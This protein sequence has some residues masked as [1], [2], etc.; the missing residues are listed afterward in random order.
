LIEGRIWKEV[1]AQE[2]KYLHK[3]EKWDLVDLPN[4][5]KPISIKWVLKKNLNRTGQVKKYKARMVAKWYSQVEGVDFIDIFSPIVKL[6]SIRVLMSLDEN[7]NIEIEKMNVNKMFLHGNLE[8]KIY[9]KLFEEF[10]I[11]GKKYMV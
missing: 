10:V 8:E 7:F 9:M 6:N 4:G 5:K 2:M 11:K 3:N 1:M